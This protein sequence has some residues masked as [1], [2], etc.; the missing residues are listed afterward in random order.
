MTPP[1]YTAIRKRGRKSVSIVVRPD[2]TVEV[3]VPHALAEKAIDQIVATKQDWINKKLK[4]LGNSEYQ[5]TEHLYLD[6]ELFLFMGRHLT[7]DITAGRGGVRINDDSLQVTVP[8]GLQGE[9]RTFYIRQKLFDHYLTE[10][11]RVLREKTITMADA[12]GVTPVYISVKNYKSRWGTCFGDGR[13]YYNWKLILAPEGIM[14]YVVAHEL[15]HLKVPNHSKRFWEFLET[16][17]PDWKA[18]RRWLKING[19]AL[20]I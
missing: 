9:D 20:S 13:I 18:R 3:I 8:P 14:E 5:R 11:Q 15:C 4:E 10:A 6:G 7:L 1:E 12:F 2:M 19:H 17:I 16:E